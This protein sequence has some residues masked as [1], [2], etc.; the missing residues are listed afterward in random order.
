MNQTRATKGVKA[1][2]LNKEEWTLELHFGCCVHS[3]LRV[4]FFVVWCLLP[5]FK[6]VA[7]QDSYL[8]LALSKINN[9]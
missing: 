7:F 3:V 9:C 8:P 4:D 6:L 5:F 1:V 2:I